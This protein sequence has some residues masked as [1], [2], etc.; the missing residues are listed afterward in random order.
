MTKI[1]LIRHGE[2]EGGNRFRGCLDDP[3]SDTG[4][5]QMYQAVG[6]SSDW[7]LI[8]SSPLLRCAAFAYDLSD[9]LGVPCIEDERLRELGFGDWE[10][11]VPADLYQEAPDALARFWSDPVAYPP[12]GGEE[13]LQFQSRVEAAWLDIQRDYPDHHLLVVAHGGV[14][15]IIIAD[16]LGMP[17]SHLFRID[18]P[19]AGVSRVC[20]EEGL[21]RLVSHGDKI[22]GEPLC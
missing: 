22:I 4:W 1:D 2:P 5:E 13:M 12:P 17:L 7:D 18:I 11:R 8:I 3:L 10:G 15:R 6:E 16:V 19:Y 20:I 21:P 9:R 14:N